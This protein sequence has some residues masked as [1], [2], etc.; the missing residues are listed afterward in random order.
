MINWLWLIPTLFVGILIGATVIAL[1]AVG[2]IS[3]QE[4]PRESS[5]DDQI[6]TGGTK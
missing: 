6:I 3:D 1:C 4:M 2:K 5:G